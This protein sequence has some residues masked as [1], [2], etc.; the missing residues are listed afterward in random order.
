MWLLDESIFKRLTVFFTQS[1]NPQ[2]NCIRPW[3][4]AIRWADSSELWEAVIS[5][6][7]ISY[8]LKSSHQGSLLVPR[9]G[10]RK[11]FYPVLVFSNFENGRGNSLLNRQ[12]LCQ[13]QKSTDRKSDRKKE[14]KEKRKKRVKYQQTSSFEEERPS[15]DWILELGPVDFWTSKRCGAR[16]GVYP[17]DIPGP[18]ARSKRVSARESEYPGRP[19][20]TFELGQALPSLRRGRSQEHGWSESESDDVVRFSHSE[21]CCCPKRRRPFRRSGSS[22]K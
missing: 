13:L 14:K 3:S 1:F 5:F 12:W 21:L 4:T 11:V 20:T 8:L 16:H 18:Q 7:Y 10:G 6:V 9:N 15:Q 19:Q 2:V 17:G 22:T